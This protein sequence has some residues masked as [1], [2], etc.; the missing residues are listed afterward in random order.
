MPDPRS[1]RSSMNRSPTSSRPRSSTWRSPCITTHRPSPGS[2]RL[3]YRQALEERNHAMM[4]VQYLIDA[5]AKVASRVSR[6]RNASTTRRAGALALDQERGSPSRSSRWLGSRATRATTLGE[7]FM[8][9]FL[10][11]Q[12][13]EVSSMSDLLRVVDRAR[14]DPCAPRS[15]SRGKR[16]ATGQGRPDGPAGSRRSALA[17]RGRGGPAH[18]LAL[19]LLPDRRSRLDL[20]DESRA[21]PRRPRHGA[22]RWPPRSPT[23]RPAAPR[24]RGAGPPPRTGR[25]V[26]SPPRRSPR[27]AGRPSRRTPRSRAAPPRASRR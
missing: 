27:S 8:Q 19:L 15:T 23:A 13:E 4:M 14:H 20:V 22:A 9:W 7:Q 11:E 10:K 1:S 2:P 16:S 17:P 3:F 25:D 6:R 18:P 21:R 12:V 5:D 26:R 24:R